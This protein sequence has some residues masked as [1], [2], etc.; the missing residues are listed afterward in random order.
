MDPDEW[1][2]VLL[3]CQ[4]DNSDQPVGE[5]RTRSP[6]EEGEESKE[7]R[8]LERKK[9]RE[10]RRRQEVN[11]RFDDLVEVL[12]SLHPGDATKKRALHSSCRSTVLAVA[13]ETIKT[14]AQENMRYKQQQ[15]MMKNAPSQ[16]QQPLPKAMMPEQQ[17]YVW[18]PVPLGCFQQQ[19]QLA[20]HLQLQPPLL[21][22]QQQQPHQSLGQ[23]GYMNPLGL[24]P[25][26]QGMHMQ[27]TIP[28][29]GQQAPAQISDQQTQDIADVF[30]KPSHAECA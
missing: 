12:T 14:L 23:L 24:A 27:Q 8:R 10:K 28:Q 16:P 13:V 17:S 30:G 25:A 26:S 6:A 19:Q 1:H 2:A 21:Q 9:F 29:L 4:E 22:S 15:L 20:P 18:M 7:A 11:E 3:C 5:K